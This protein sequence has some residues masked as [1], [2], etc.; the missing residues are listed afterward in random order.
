MPPFNIIHIFWFGTAQIISDANNKSISSKGLATLAPF[1]ANI[2]SFRPSG[3]AITD[4]HAINIV[5]GM[6]VRYLGR[7]T[8]TKTD[9]LSYVVKWSDIDQTL[10]SALVN[11]IIA[12]S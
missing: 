8:R 3:I 5:D 11:E 7:C 12:S 1:V 4:Y 6:E 2:V 10:L 9:K